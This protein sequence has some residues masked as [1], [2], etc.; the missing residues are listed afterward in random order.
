MKK[1]TVVYSTPLTSPILFGTG[2]SSTHYWY[3]ETDNLQEA[4]KGYDVN[5][6][7]EGHPKIEESYKED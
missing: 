5:F 2:A 6:I 7:F 3:I 1:Y 4:I